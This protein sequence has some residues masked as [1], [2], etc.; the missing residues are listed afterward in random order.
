M[1]KPLFIIF[2][3]VFS[4]VTHADCYIV[5]DSSGKLIHQ[6]SESPVDIELPFH[7]TVP[8][9]FGKGATL[10]Y[11]IGAQNCADI[12]PSAR[13]KSTGGLDSSAYFSASTPIDFGPHSDADPFKGG[14]AGRSHGAIQTGSR[15]GQFYINSGGNRTYV[16]RR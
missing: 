6:S 8:E 2:G 14:G 3:L 11:Q 10:V 9:R 5:Y 13:M 12:N 4:L 15:G 1:K 7:M 16:P